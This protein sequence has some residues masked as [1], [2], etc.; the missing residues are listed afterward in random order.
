MARSTALSRARRHLL[1]EIRLLEVREAAQTDPK[2]LIAEINA[3]DPTTLERFRFS[4]FPADA[5]ALWYGETP[6]GDE[7]WLWQSALVDWWTGVYNPLF[8]QFE[9]WSPNFTFDPSQRVFMTLKARQLGVTWTAMALELWY[10]L[11]RPGSRC[12]IYS[13]NEDEAKKAIT[14]AWLMYKSLPAVLRSHV[15]VITPNRA[16]DPSEFIKV[17]HKESGLISSIQAL[18]A[19]PKAGHGDTITFAA[20]DEAAYA[21]HAR[22]IFKAILPATGRGNARLAI[23][24]T[25]NGLGNP[26]SGEGNF[27]NILYETMHERGLAF[28]FVPWNAEPTRDMDWYMRVAMKLDEVERNQS[29]PLNESDAFMLS[30]NLYF[31]REG[32]AYY[33]DH[34]IKPLLR[35]Q[36]LQ[37]GIRKLDWMSLRDGIVEIFEKP[38]EGRKYGLAIDTATGRGTDYTS[39]G[40][41]DLETGAFCAELHAKIDASRAVIQAHAL[42]KWYNTAKIAVER[43]GGY[44]EALITF[45][46]D[47]TVGLPPYP[48]LYRHVDYTKGNKPISQEYGMPM[49]AKTRTQVI[50]GLADW[51][52]L[53]MFPWLSTG[54]VSELGHFVHANTNPSPRAMDGANDDRVMMLAILTDLYRQF[55]RP[56][57]KK[58]KR[59]KKRKYEPHPSRRQ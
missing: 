18:P 55:G 19:T 17:R 44:G 59:G 20:I 8:E 54:I 38:V 23:I 5:D 25:A 29:Y 57:N 22:A 50:T 13:Y 49:G 12:V 2:A 40:V 15:E 39:M 30:G 35:G 33:R 26:E 48:N 24:S 3:F 10:M 46:R 1:E 51:I 53:R 31:D 42:G 47:G 28:S 9:E 34:A 45:L 43:Q 6:R 27:F 52:R 7:G 58:K 4:M 56:P 37:N 32:L 14:R 41:I 21:D 16:E 36:F 11:F